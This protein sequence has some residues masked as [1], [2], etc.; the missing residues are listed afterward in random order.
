MRINFSIVAEEEYC[1]LS[2]AP[3]EIDGFPAIASLRLDTV[4]QKVSP[5]RIAV[6][7]ILA[8]GRY[9]SGQVQFDSKISALTAEL[10]ARFMRPRWVHVTPL[11]P[12]NLPIP[13]GTKTVRL[14]ESISRIASEAVLVVVRSDQY[15]GAIVGRNA[16]IVASNAWIIDQLDAANE[17]DSLSA[18][19]AVA[20]LMAEQ[21]D[22]AVI[23]I[24]NI[25]HKDAPEISA[26]KEL[27]GAVGLGMEFA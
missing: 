13:R 5:D 12:A 11:H 20:V 24:E 9:L 26:L 21:M 3:G 8:F 14:T 19:L 22:T 18:R 4:P 17:I 2:A 10:I 15:Q 6:A 7:G 23:R 1:L 27:L 16:T 25:D